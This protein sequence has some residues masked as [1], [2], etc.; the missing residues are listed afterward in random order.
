MEKEILF[1]EVQKFRQWW[2]WLIL[3]AASMPLVGIL[4]YQLVTGIPVGDKPLS[5][6]AL[7]VLVI[8]ISGP[9][10]LG[11]YFFKLFTVIDTQS[12]HYGFGISAGNLNEIHLADIATMDVVPYRA[13]GFGMRLSNEF[14]TIYNTSGGMGLFIIN[15]KGTKMVIGTKKPEELKAAIEKMRT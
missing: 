15:N 5:N 7:V 8:F 2:L 6:G 3:I 12:I 9:M 14:G 1:T 10:L 13:N 11:F 4:I